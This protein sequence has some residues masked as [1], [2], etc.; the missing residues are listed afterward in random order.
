MLRRDSARP[1]GER[2]AMAS[3]M[4]A[5]PAPP[6]YANSPTA[7]FVGM[8]KRLQPATTFQGNIGAHQ[9]NPSVA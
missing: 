1:Q 5:W 6:L 2:N 7:M 3:P 9:T 4:Q 8:W